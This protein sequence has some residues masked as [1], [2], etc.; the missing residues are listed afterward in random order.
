MSVETEDALINMSTDLDDELT[1]VLVGRKG[2]FKRFR[3]WA[4]KR[5]WDIY[6]VFGLATISI[7]VRT[8]ISLQDIIMRMPTFCL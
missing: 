3:R 6:P 7:I 1:T 5:L 4:G 2:P 8:K